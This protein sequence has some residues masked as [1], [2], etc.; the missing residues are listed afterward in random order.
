MLEKTKKIWFPISIA[1]FVIPEILWSPLV[2]SYY[3][4]FEPSI[5]GSSQIWKYSFLPE[6][7]NQNI[8]L[9]VLFVQLLGLVISFFV[10]LKF[11]NIFLKVFLLVLFVGLIVASGL[12]F[13]TT[14]YYTNHSIGF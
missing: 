4:L 9:L 3:S 13:Y 8:F 10:C 2:G 7:T 1:L 11:N 14:F 12:V 5:H 6:L